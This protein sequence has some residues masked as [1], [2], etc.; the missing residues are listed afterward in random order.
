MF[1]GSHIK[2]NTFVSSIDR[3]YISGMFCFI[4]SCIRVQASPEKSIGNAD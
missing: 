1:Y 3:L 4:F 2:E